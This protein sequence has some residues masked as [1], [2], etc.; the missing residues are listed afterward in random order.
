[1]LKEILK[2]DQL[3]DQGNT[4]P[5]QLAIKSAE[6]IKHLNHITGQCSGRALQENIRILFGYT[7]YASHHTGFGTLLALLETITNTNI[8]FKYVYQPINTAEATELTPFNF[9]G[10]HQENLQNTT[11]YI[12]HCP[13][14]KTFLKTFLAGYP[15]YTDHE[16]KDLKEELKQRPAQ[17]LEII[18]RAPQLGTDDILIITDDINTELL[19]KIFLKLP[20]F[21]KLNEELPGAEELIKLFK[22]LQETEEPGTNINTGE[23]RHITK[24]IF[25]ALTDCIK[26]LNLDKISTNPFT[27]NLATIKNNITLKELRGTLNEAIAQIHQLEETLNAQYAKKVNTERQLMSA[28]QHRPEDTKAFIETIETSKAIEVLDSTNETL[29]IRITAPVQH[30]TDSDL[31]A[32]EQN[33]DSTYCLKLREHPILKE[34][35]HK[36]FVTKEYKLLLQAVVNIELNLNTT[37]IESAMRFYTVRPQLTEY[38]ELPNPHLFHYDC[39]GRARS[40]IYNHLI[41]GDY[42]LV[43]IQMVAAVQSLNIAEYPSFVD[44]FLNNLIQ[45]PTFQKLATIIDQ[46]N[47]TYSLYELLHNP[48]KSSKEPDITQNKAYTQVEIEDDDSNW[49]NTPE[50]QNNTE[51]EYPF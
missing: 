16:F 13:K 42:E 35:L 40:E 14:G 17:Y 46:G 9:F 36:I 3:W 23:Y 22:M 25:A 38:T 28:K 50:I 20:T 6:A 34:I 19:T 32:Y 15:E 31:I 47:E 4:I 48:N 37:S 51:E 5:K 12:M 44:K 29:T 30:Y 45:Q 43:I 21:V 1:M 11:V 49:E 7:W 39:W 18:K 8:H 27:E 2:A 26:A 10:T 41:N 33:K 24:D